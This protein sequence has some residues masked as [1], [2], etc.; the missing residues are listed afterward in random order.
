MFFS[1]FS[2]SVQMRDKNFGLPCFDGADKI[3][4]FVVEKREIRSNVFRMGGTSYALPVGR[5]VSDLT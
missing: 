5:F 4:R 1:F 3:R 2:F